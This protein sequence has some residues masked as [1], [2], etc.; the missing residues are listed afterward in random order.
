MSHE[1]AREAARAILPYGTH[2][3]VG[4]AHSAGGITQEEFDALCRRA[5]AAY[6]AA[7]KNLKGNRPPQ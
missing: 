3:K 2:L 1:L 4:R 7:L 6:E 5:A